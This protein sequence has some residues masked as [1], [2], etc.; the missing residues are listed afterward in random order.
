MFARTRE[1]NR[2]ETNETETNRQ[3]KTNPPWGFD[4]ITTKNSCCILDNPSKH[5]KMMILFILLDSTAQWGKFQ[6]DSLLFCDLWDVL[7]FWINRIN[8]IHN[9]PHQ[10]HSTVFRT[11]SML[12][13]VVGSGIKKEVNL[14]PLTLC[15]SAEVQKE[16]SYNRYFA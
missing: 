12:Q 1:L 3:N 15:A 2:R 11:N 16:L 8:R 4:N 5:I 6:I 13:K 14:K 7:L 9:F 10:I